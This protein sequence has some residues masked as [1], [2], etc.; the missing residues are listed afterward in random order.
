MTWIPVAVVVAVAVIVL[1]VFLFRRTGGNGHAEAPA[2]DLDA[3][4][5]RANAAADEAAQD[6]A[7]IGA[8]G[9]AILVHDVRHQDI[10]RRAHL[11]EADIRAALQSAAR[12]QSA[13]L[14]RHLKALAA[15]D[16]GEAARLHHEH[17]Q[18]GFWRF[19]PQPVPP[20]VLRLAHRQGA[21]LVR[22]GGNF[23]LLAGG[24]FADGFSSGRRHESGGGCGHGECRADGGLQRLPEAHLEP[25][26]FI[27]C[28][29]RGTDL[30]ARR[31]E[32]YS[33]RKVPKSLQSKIL[34]RRAAFHGSS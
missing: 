31:A 27:N 30:S 2:R 22:T 6:A 11:T 17:L 18:Q 21:E 19:Q 7:D 8:A 13:F 3:E 25:H 14:L 33:K 24:L 28:C 9:P 23:G 4:R 34:P 12:G 29:P 20:A 1:L 16:Q 15:I 10:V 5:Q 32:S 26:Y